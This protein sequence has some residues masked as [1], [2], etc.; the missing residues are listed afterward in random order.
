MAILFTA[1]A[2]VKDWKALQALHRETLLERAKRARAS[3][4]QIFRNVNDASRMLMILELPDYDSVR[5]LSRV[6]LEV[7]SPLLGSGPADDGCWE[8]TG[9]EDVTAQH[10]EKGGASVDRKT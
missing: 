9:W 7:I 3:Q 5:E 4:F 1:T 10:V 2:R 6:L 8:P